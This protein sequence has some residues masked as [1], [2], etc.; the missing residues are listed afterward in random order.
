MNVKLL[1]VIVPAYKQQRSIK[2]DL[3]NIEKTLKQLRFD[4]EIICV[5]DGNVDKTCEEAKKIRSKK[6]EVV[7]YEQNRGKGYAVR[8]GMA[9]AKGELI[10]FIDSGMDINPF[11]ISMLLE[12]MLWYDSDVI[13]GS[14]RHS[15]SRVIGYPLK[16]KIFSIGYHWLTRILFGLRITDSQRGLKIFRREVLEKVLPR[17]LVKRFAFDIEMLAVAYRLGFKKIHDGPVEMDARKFKYSSIKTSTVLD[18]LWD[19]MA[20]FYR[21]RL[22]RYYDN[23]NKREWFLDKELNHDSKNLIGKL[24]VS[25]II[26]VRT[27]TS[28]LKETI[29]CLKKQ[30]VKNLEIIVVTDKKEKI[31]GAR[32][33]PSGEPT[34]AYKR[35]LGAAYASGQILAFLDDD[36]Y[37]SEGWL[38]NALYVFLERKDIVAVCGPALTPPS[39]NIYQKTSG[40]VWASWLGSGGAGVYR[41][42][43]SSRKEVDDFPSVN[44]LIKKKDFE[45]VG[46]FDESHWPGE[47]TKLC[48]DLIKLGKKIIY[49]PGV[50]VFHHRRPV[51]IPHLKQISR[52]AVRRGFF[53]R[54]FPETSFR[55][56]YFFPSFF[57]YGLVFGGILSII[58]P[59]IRSIYYLLFTTYY[60]LLLLSGFE[61]LV[62]EKNLR[63]G[64]YV[65][66]SIFATHLVYGFLFPF[67][68]FSKSLATVPHKVDE[69]RKAYVGG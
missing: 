21:L 47:D 29:E 30:S 23:K 15:A 40:W 11:G 25:V 44:L 38:K 56:G 58:S 24:R 4:Y 22:W 31:S 43:I 32:V 3:R 42:R 6:I 49:D 53:A 7:G 14:V 51:L 55:I 39:D 2:R 17:L 65:M 63:S 69:A 20:I 28:Y 54:V 12:H 19:T 36:S 67:G 61:V 8:Y 45:K 10:A 48:L 26:P 57:A 27:A 13:V 59:I 68:F 66:F 64:L 5:V 9:R 37:P 34:P 35:N 18:M 62:R 46:G 52:Y 50:L 60:L 1:S 33:I 16:R 41:N